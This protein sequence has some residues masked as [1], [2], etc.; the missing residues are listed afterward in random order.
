M[1]FKCSRVFD[2]FPPAS[3]TAPRMMPIPSDSSTRRVTT[4][5]NKASAAGTTD[6]NECE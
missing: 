5:S 4:A 6:K 3:S 1:S 2:G